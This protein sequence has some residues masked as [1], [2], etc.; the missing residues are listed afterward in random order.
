MEDKT[1]VAVMSGLEKYVPVEQEAVAELLPT[2]ELT[3]D[4]CVYADMKKRTAKMQLLLIK[5]GE[6]SL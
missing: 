3:C 6:R 1:N 4:L 2:L 5:H